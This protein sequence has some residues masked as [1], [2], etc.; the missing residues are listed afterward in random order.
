MKETRTYHDPEDKCPRENAMERLLERADWL[1]DERKDR[2][3][4]EAMYKTPDPRDNDNP[5]YEQG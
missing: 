2:E 4:E 3:M 5:Y 1:R